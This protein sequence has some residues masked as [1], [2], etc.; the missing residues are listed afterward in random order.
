MK[1]IIALLIAII[2]LSSISVAAVTTTEISETELS[3]NS[4]IAVDDDFY[5]LYYDGE[6]FTDFDIEGADFSDFEE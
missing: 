4:V 5:G 3:P 2:C 6:Y 1:K